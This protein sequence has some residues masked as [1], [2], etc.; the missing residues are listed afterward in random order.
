[1]IPRRQMLATFLATPLLAT[2]A[3]SDDSE[4]KPT[5]G[6]DIVDL[7]KYGAVGDGIVDDTAA[8]QAAFDAASN[9]NLLL[10]PQGKFKVTSSIK[11]K[12]L[13]NISGFGAE[14]SEFVLDKA[15]TLQYQGKSA[16]DY[17]SDQ[18]TIRNVGFRCTKGRPRSSGAVIDIHFAGGKGGTAKSAILEDVEVSG[19][20]EGSGFDCAIRLVNARNLK[21]DGARIR[22][23][24]NSRGN[25]IGI[26]LAGDE[27]P[28]DIFISNISCYFLHRAI[29]I[30]GTVEGV[31]LSQSVFVAIDYGVYARPPHTNPLLFVQN[32]HINAFRSCIDIN[33]MVQFDISHN[34]LYAAKPVKPLAPAEAKL[35]FVAISI[36]MHENIGVTSRI[37]GNTI[38]GTLPIDIPKNGIYVDGER[39]EF[40]LSIDGNEL[41]GWDT[42][43]ILG[44]GANGVLV[45]ASNRFRSNQDRVLDLSGKNVFAS[46]SADS[47]GYSRDDNGIETKWGTN[48]VALDAQGGGRIAFP[49]PFRN[50]LHFCLG[51]N[52]DPSSAGSACFAVNQEKST[53]AELRFAVTPNPGA[54]T[55]RL[56]WVAIGT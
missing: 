28:V 10:I 40:S 35:G 25:S 33:N 30:G 32:C 19:A 23:D 29:N 45:S 9:G 52:G 1:M 41:I 14:T 5:K 54:I 49:K 21:I 48:V 56:N 7:R 17:D 26:D 38:I 34:L 47:E 44:A 27:S 15:A 42:A 6:I 31:Y 16:N 22:G 2:A 46:S 20:E 18:I 37:S 12:G 50:K 43:V 51:A 4:R 24:R 39:S 8:V 11:L 55:V 13:V 53:A 36:G 3:T